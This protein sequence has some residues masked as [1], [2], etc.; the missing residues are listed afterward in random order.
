[1]APLLALQYLTLLLVEIA[2]M[3]L[4]MLDAKLIVDATLLALN[5]HYDDK[6]DDPLVISVADD[7]CLVHYFVH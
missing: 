6:V 4:Q 3:A 7:K 2:L 1:M 5:Y